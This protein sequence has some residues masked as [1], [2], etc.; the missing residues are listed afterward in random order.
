MRKRRERIAAERCHRPRCEIRPCHFRT[1]G[2]IEPQ[3]EVQSARPD[4]IAIAR[5]E[6]CCGRRLAA[7]GSRALS[8]ALG[9]AS[10]LTGQLKKRASPPG[11]GELGWLFSVPRFRNRP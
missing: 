8:E 3:A 1:I 7:R 10:R 5:L 6:S 2:R 9:F 11:W 4:Q